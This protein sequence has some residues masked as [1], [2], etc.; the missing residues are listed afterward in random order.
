[1]RIRNS[2]TARLLLALVVPMSALAIVFGAGGTI[3]TRQVV[4][5]SADRLLAGAVRAIA[6][7]LTVEN[8]E[9]W[10][11]IPPWALGVLDN[12]ERDR[13][14]Y[15][16]RQGDSLLSGY[17][18]LPDAPPARPEE[19]PDFRYVEYKGVRIR[20]AT[21]SVQLVG[22]AAPVVVSVAQSLDSRR[23]V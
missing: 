16:V 18:D 4:D 6:E 3:V 21:Q 2:L 8:G 22:V 10:V 9:V 13:V 7:T 17:E 20:Q 15:S 12:P 1:M 14:Y 19:E 5:R 23:A 11:N